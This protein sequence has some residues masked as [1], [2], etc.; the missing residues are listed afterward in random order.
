MTI[1][2]KRTVWKLR[3]QA[4]GMT[5][6]AVYY[7]RISARKPTTPSYLSSPCSLQLLVQLLRA[8]RK[9]G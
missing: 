1:M 5:T 8:A 6:T 7:G 2:G 3:S 4:I 9:A